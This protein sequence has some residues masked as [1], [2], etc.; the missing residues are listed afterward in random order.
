M[1]SSLFW[2]LCV[3]EERGSIQEV[4]SRISWEQLV[5][6]VVAELWLWVVTVEAGLW[7]WV[8]RGQKGMQ[9]L[10]LQEWLHQGQPDQGGYRHHHFQ[11]G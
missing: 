1:T 8:M 4:Q 9:E 2:H 6:M 11:F 7:Q 3:E 10:C 5:M